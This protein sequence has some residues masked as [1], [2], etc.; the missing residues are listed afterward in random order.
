MK[1]VSCDDAEQ[2]WCLQVAL[3]SQV[4]SWVTCGLGSSLPWGW[5]GTPCVYFLTGLILLHQYTML[6]L[7]DAAYKRQQ[8]AVCACLLRVLSAAYAVCTLLHMFVNLR[9]FASNDWTLAWSSLA[10]VAE[11]AGYALLWRTGTIS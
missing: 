4:S 8:L 10:A 7:S 6:V 1:E 9:L 5:R 2:H 3:W 11:A